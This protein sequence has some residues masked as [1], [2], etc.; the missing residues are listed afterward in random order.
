MKTIIIVHDDTIRRTIHNELNALSA[1]Y[2]IHI[3]VPII[4]GLSRQY[5]GEQHYTVHSINQS[6]F[7]LFRPIGTKITNIFN[8]L[9]YVFAAARVVRNTRTDLAVIRTQKLPFIYKIL[10]PS[11]INMVMYYHAEL[12]FTLKGR[13]YNHVSKF[14]SRWFNKLIIDTEQNIIDQALPREKCYIC[15]FGFIPRKFVERNFDS[16]HLIYVGVLGKRN[17][18][19]TIY[20]FK[21]FW[22]E[23]GSKINM[24]YNIVGFV[25]GEDKQLIQEALKTAGDDTPIKYYGWLSDDEVDTMFGK[26]NIGVAYNRGD[27]YYSNFISFKLHEYLLSGLVVTSVKSELRNAIVNDTNGVLHDSSAEGFYDALVHIYNHLDT[28]DSNKIRESDAIY[29]LEYNIQNI[30]VPMY[31]KLIETK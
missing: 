11:S 14:S 20:G 7:K 12:T 9:Y 13:L 28:Y 22:D 29:S 15:G 4:P 10:L 23:Y 25:E 5:S 24:S 8:A 17:I 18:H 31:K 21:R 26:A 3:V 2:N 30:Q 16:M 1:Y 6:S 19:E 27:S